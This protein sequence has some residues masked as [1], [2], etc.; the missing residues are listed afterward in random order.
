MLDRLHKIPYNHGRIAVTTAVAA[1]EIHH[2]I[3][4]ITK[5]FFIVQRNACL[6]LLVITP[7]VGYIGK[8]KFVGIIQA[9]PA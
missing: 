4:V 1:G 9:G 2:K 8:G 6:Q 5:Y 7:A 3:P